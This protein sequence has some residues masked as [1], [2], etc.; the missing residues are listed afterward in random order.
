M[1]KFGKSKLEFNA[2]GAANE[3]EQIY[4]KPN[5][6]EVFSKCY[7]V[8]G[9]KNGSIEIILDSFSKRLKI[10]IEMISGKK[11]IKNTLD[12]VAIPQSNAKKMS[13]N[14]GEMSTE[15]VTSVEPNWFQFLPKYFSNKNHTIL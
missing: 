10:F 6:T 15:E 2:W 11:K 13:D 12:E 4:Q 1:L 9:K 3:G 5:I 14:S 8:F 7:N